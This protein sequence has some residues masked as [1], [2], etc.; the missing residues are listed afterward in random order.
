MP[1][2][3][4]QE[5]TLHNAFPTGRLYLLDCRATIDCI[6]QSAKTGLPLS[7]RKGT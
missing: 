6:L 4:T 1:H 3:V 7:A 2:K 5:Q